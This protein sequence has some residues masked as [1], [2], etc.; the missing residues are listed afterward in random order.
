MS[1][2]YSSSTDKSAGLGI[3]AIMFMA[4]SNAL[5]WLT[6]PSNMALINHTLGSIAAVG[7]IVLVIYR[8]RD[9]LRRKR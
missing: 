6:E 1:H 4:L 2:D 5:A 9:Y 8:L 7:S 3:L